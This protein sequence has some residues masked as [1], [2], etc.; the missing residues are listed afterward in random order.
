M[1]VPPSSKKSSAVDKD[2]L[3]PAIPRPIS[4]GILTLLASLT[5]DGDSPGT[6]GTAAGESW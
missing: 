1:M 3:I 4:T 5:A 6:L 2:W